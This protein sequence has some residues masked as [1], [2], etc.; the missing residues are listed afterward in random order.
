MIIPQV[1]K[2]RDVQ[3]PVRSQFP[4]RTPPTARKGQEDRR[5]QSGK[6]IPHGPSQGGEHLQGRANQRGEKLKDSG[7]HKAIPLSAEC[8]SAVV[9]TML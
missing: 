8:Q 1:T 5:C 6:D 3:G 9:S 7:K 4:K 2:Y